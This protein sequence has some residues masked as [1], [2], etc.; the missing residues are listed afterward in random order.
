VYSSQ[1]TLQDTVD[2][3]ED[4]IIIDMLNYSLHFFSQIEIHK[5]KLSVAD[6]KSKIEQ[7]VLQL[8]IPVQVSFD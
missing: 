7:I 6:F 5:K 1:T 4:I 2:F 8:K 3:R